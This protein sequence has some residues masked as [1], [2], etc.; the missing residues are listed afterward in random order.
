M[1]MAASRG[2]PQERGGVALHARSQGSELIRTERRRG[3]PYGGLRRLSAKALNRL[4]E[5]LASEIQK[6]DIAIASL[7]AIGGKSWVR[8]CN[9]NQRSQ[10]SDF[11]ALVQACEE[12]GVE[13]EAR[14][15][16]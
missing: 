5:S 1:R 3:F 4:N 13:H 9:L 15:G 2:L 8:V 11:E 16:H 12:L 10:R 7:Y 14:T 6:R